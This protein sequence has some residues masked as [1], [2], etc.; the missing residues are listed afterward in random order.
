MSLQF[1]TCPRCQQDIS[2]ERRAS[3]VIVCDHCGFVI[4]N[5]EDD[6]SDNTDKKFIRLALI[7]AFVL[8]AGFLQLATWD[9]HFAEVIPLQLKEIAG[10]SSNDDLE[11]M[12]SICLERRKFDCVEKEYSKLGDRD[13]KNLLRLG[14]FQMSRAHYNEAVNTYRN[15]FAKGGVDLDGSYMFAKALGQVGMV[16]EAAK[17]YDYVLGAKPDVLQV[18]VVQSYVKLLMEAHRLDQAKKLIEEVRHKSETS[19]YFMEDEYKKIQELTGA[20][21]HS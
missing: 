16:D 14:K 18:T 7:I 21:A 1:G 15:F 5:S 20:V 4:S 12:A 3:S 13:L 8:I 10:A 6:Y 17:Y 11:R 2:P 9:S 19:A